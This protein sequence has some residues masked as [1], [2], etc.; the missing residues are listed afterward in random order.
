MPTRVVTPDLTTFTKADRGEI[1]RFIRRLHT[2]GAG[3]TRRQA[4]DVLVR[5]QARLGRDPGVKR[6]IRAEFR[7]VQFDAIAE[8]H[9]RVVPIRKLASQ[10]ARAL[11]E[12]P[13]VSEGARTAARSILVELDSLRS[14]SHGDDAVK[15]HQMLLAAEHRAAIRALTGSSVRTIDLAGALVLFVFTLMKRELPDLSDSKL[16]MLVAAYMQAFYPRLAQPTTPQVRSRVSVRKARA[17]S[18]RRVDAKGSK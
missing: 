16:S 4:R 9:H 14:Q 15:P 7:R 1:G 6:A 5:L 13:D 8:R 18:R 2:S 12:N 3:L 10:L 17:T 11:D